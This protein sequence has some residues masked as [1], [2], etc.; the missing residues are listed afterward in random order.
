MQKKQYQT[1]STF[2][3]LPGGAQDPGESLVEALH[4]ECQEELGTEVIAGEIIRLA[5]FYKP[6][7]QPAL[8]Q[9]QHQLD[10]LFRCQLAEEAYTPVNG[11]HWD[12]HPVAIEWI[13]I[14]RLSEIQLSL[15][16]LQPMLFN[17]HAPYQPIYLG[18]HN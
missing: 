16:F 6:K 17:I 4:R 18:K 9:Q 12:K 13:A 1:K 3:S 11:P 8:Y 5:N 10:V 15:S 2:Y 14:D 7:S